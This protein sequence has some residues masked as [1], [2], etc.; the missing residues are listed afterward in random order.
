NESTLMNGRRQAFTL[1]E[2]IEHIVEEKN[3][4]AARREAYVAISR[5]KRYCTI[6]YALESTTGSPL[7]MAHILS[8]ISENHATVHSLN[9]STER[10]MNGNPK[11][12]ITSMPLVESVGIRTLVD[13]VARE[14]VKDTVSVTSLNS[15]FE[16]PWKWYFN[17]FL[18][19]PTPKT[20]SLILGSIVH[21]SIEAILKNKT[22]PSKSALTHVIETSL[23][24]ELVKDKNTRA[25]LGTV[26]QKILENWIAHYYPH[27][28]PNFLTERSVAYHDK[29]MP[30]LR[31]YG[32]IDLT[33]KVIDGVIVTD[34]KTGNSKTKNVIE[35]RD[36]EGR[37][38][39]LLRQLAMY[40]YLLSGE[41]VTRSKLLFLEEDPKAKNAVYE[42]HISQEEIDLLVRD[43]R[44]YDQLLANGKWVE[45]PCNFTPYGSG[46]PDCPF[47]KK[48]EIYRTA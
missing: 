17:C 10:I 40:S 2:S 41:T 45:R 3:E 11:A 44:E 42:T 8:E 27:I 38:S 34:F 48:A 28:H 13:M 47:C 18:Q 14:Y 25:H 43:I 19:L 37:M 4:L 20:E 36:E 29:S 1:P 21:E 5:A 23:D 6:S 24:I 46:D 22:K 32:K 26:A 12:Y 9:E 15:F 35:K 31:L 33:E 39:S 7:E 16:C 30:H